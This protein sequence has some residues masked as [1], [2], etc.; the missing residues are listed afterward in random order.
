MPHIALML[1]CVLIATCIL[2][3]CMHTGGGVGHNIRLSREYT[4]TE[5]LF[6]RKGSQSAV[7]GANGGSAASAA[8]AAAAAVP[9][10]TIA[11]RA[12]A[13]KAARVQSD[14]KQVAPVEH[15]EEVVRYS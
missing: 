11:Q 4:G 12:S 1:I 2:L 14:L 3:Y 6:S 8:T 9:A 7:I 13:Y 5:P 15:E 10:M